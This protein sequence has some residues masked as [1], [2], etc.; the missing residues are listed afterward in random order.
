MRTGAAIN[1][2]SAIRLSSL[3]NQ[4]RLL[5]ILNNISPYT[6]WIDCQGAAQTR[7][8]KR[9]QAPGREG[10]EVDLPRRTVHD[11][12]AHRLA[13][14]GRVEHAPDIVAGRHVGTVNTRHGTDK[15]KAVFGDRPEARLPR[16]DRRRGE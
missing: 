8:I 15:G 14:R 3:A 7:W 9:R 11:Q 16:F 1:L 6:E 2:F 10:R 13:G 5:R 12:F 4:S